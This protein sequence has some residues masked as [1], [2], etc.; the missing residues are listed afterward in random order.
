MTSND[1][2]R[3]RAAHHWALL[4]SGRAESVRAGGERVPPPRA[5]GRAASVRAGAARLAA[6]GAGGLFV[7]QI[8]AP[9]W[10]T[11]GAAAMA[12][13]MDLASGI[14]LGF[15]RSPLETAMAALDLDRLPG[16]R[17]TRAIGSSTQAANEDRF[18][19]PY[20]KPV[21][22]LRELTELLHRMVT[23]EEQGGIG[24]FEGEFFHLA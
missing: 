23:T 3:V 21:S 16:A 12:G 15:V 4:P 7:P 17:S 11:L 24:R 14:A 1:V 8:F 22:R 18:G 13:D 10:A 5:P 19:V 2:A 9:P 20:A 6:T